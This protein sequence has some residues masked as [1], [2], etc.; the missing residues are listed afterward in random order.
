MSFEQ[1]N[2]IIL[3]GMGKHFDKRLEPYY[4]KARN[5]FEEYYGNI[6][7]NEK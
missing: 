6:E 2:Q 7:K 3:D 5:K 1:A 4:L